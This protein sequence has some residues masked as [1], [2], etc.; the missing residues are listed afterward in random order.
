MAKRKRKGTSIRI[1]GNRDDDE[2]DDDKPKLIVFMIGGLTY[3]EIRVIR[4]L[5]ASKTIQSVAI[6]GGTTLM[7][8]KEYVEGVKN[9]SGDGGGD[10]GS[11][12]DGGSEGEEALDVDLGSDS[13]SDSGMSD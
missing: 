13:G 12:G 7:Q 9:M 6:L 8:P 2:E 10:G 4:G 1:G 3:P 5:E 11:D